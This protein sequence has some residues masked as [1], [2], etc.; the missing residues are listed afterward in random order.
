MAVS[1]TKASPTLRFSDAEVGAAGTAYLLGAVAGA[2]LFGWL[3]DRLGRKKLFFITIA[4]YLTATALT[5]LSWN[6]ASFLLFRFVTGCGIG[7]ENAAI[8]STI[9]EIVPSR[10]RGF[11]DLVEVDPK[12]LPNP[13]GTPGRRSDSLGGNDRGESRGRVLSKRLGGGW[14]HLDSCWRSGRSG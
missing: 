13:A 12:Q 14:H 10:Y 6:L 3:T 9:Q 7:G 4:V 1:F 2:L 5:G 11:V 8:N